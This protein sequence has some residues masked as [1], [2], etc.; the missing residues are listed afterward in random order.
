M[1]D[2]VLSDGNV[3]STAL[4]RYKEVCRLVERPRTYAI[5]VGVLR[6]YAYTKV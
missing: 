1:L 4:S 5:S 3:G 6:Y 2:K